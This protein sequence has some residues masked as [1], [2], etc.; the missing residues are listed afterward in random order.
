[1]IGFADIIC[2]PPTEN[3]SEERC[4]TIDGHELCYGPMGCCD[5]IKN[6]YLISFHCYCLGW[7]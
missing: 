4:H 2:L 6:T 1:M 7:P 3:N 5:M